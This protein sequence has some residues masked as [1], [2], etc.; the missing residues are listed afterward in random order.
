MGLKVKNEG[1]LCRISKGPPI[2]NPR[3]IGQ[4]DKGFRFYYQI[5]KIDNYNKQIKAPRQ[6]WITMCLAS[7]LMID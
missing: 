1:F 4:S 2:C 5:L 3:E 6:K 7:E